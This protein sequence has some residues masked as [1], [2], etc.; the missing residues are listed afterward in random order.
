ML[1]GDVQRA[2]TSQADRSPSHGAAPREY[3]LKLVG[4][5]ADIRALKARIDRHTGDP[6]AWRGQTL[7]T[8]YFDTADRDLMAT[9]GVLRVRKAGRRFIQCI[10]VA[11]GDAGILDR[12]EWETPVPGPDPNPD[13]TLFPAEALRHLA[14]I[15][16]K[17]LEHLFTT[18]F[19]RRSQLV[20]HPSS[21]GAPA[22]IEI[23]L[24]K[25][26]VTAGG[27]SDPIHEVEFELKRGDPRD[28]FDLVLNVTDGTGM[29]PSPISKAKRGHR[30][31]LGLDGL[32]AVFAPKPTLD[33]STT[34]SETLA[35]VFRIG[36]QTLTANEPVA[37]DGADAEGIHQMRVAIRRMRTA[38]SVFGTF[39]E[40]DRLTGRR[41][42]SNG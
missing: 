29:R 42:N 27:R 22:L 1:K 23:A 24:D 8:V 38:L 37:I 7:T 2:M 9:G 5:A 30:L 39:I 13:F 21:F 18:R 19:H 3:E 31:A 26:E 25:G 12:A 40:P 17:P 10:K 4:T 11:A 34:V 32:Q 16:D 6:K 33:P 14:A 41:S 36:L 28:L 15:V 20:S 35:T